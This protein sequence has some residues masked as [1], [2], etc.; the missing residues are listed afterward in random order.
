VPK[1]SEEIP[2]Q[3]IQLIDPGL[4]LRAGASRCDVVEALFFPS[5]VSLKMSEGNEALCRFLDVG[6]M[7]AQFLSIEE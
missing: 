2:R 6:R 4:N 3:P 7:S 5:Q 1:W